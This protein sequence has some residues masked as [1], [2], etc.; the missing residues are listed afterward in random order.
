M[1]HQVLPS[2]RWPLFELCLARWPKC[3]HSR[4]YLSID[5]M[6][7][8]VRSFLILRRDLGLLY[9]D[10]DAPLTELEISFRDYVMAEQELRRR[11]LYLKALQYWRGRLDSLPALRSDSLGGFTAS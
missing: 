9:E 10:P 11:P 6:I 1:S 5:M 4:L 2:D 3:K 8:D 7:A